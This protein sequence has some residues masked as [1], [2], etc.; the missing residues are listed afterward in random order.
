MSFTNIP[1]RV[2]YILLLQLSFA[3]Y[4]VLQ[5]SFSDYQ[6]DRDLHYMMEHLNSPKVLNSY[7]HFKI[8][9]GLGEIVIVKHWSS[10][11]QRGV[12][13]DFERNIDG[14]LTCFQVCIPDFYKHQL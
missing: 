10:Q 11:W 7:E 1:Y 13:R 4:I 8:P 12:I 9:P 3:T 2:C 5:I 14:D 6:L